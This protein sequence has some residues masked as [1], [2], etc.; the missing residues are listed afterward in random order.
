MSSTA[1]VSGLMTG[2]RRRPVRQFAHEP[3]RI[4]H[5]VEI[6]EISVSSGAAK[7]PYQAIVSVVAGVICQ[8]SVVSPVSFGYRICHRFHFAYMRRIFN[9][10]LQSGH[11]TVSPSRS[12]SRSKTFP[13]DGQ[14]IWHI[15]VPIASSGSCALARFGFI[16]H[17]HSAHIGAGISLA[18]PRSQATAPAG[19]RHA[20]DHL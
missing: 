7:R 17:S 6:A 10:V 8:P 1:G 16:C 11:S 18:S 4:Y 9:L 3:V 15:I 2:R 14:S 12:P 5:P 19:I 20:I 13:Q